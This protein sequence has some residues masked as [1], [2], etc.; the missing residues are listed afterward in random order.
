[1]PDSESFEAFY[2]R[3]VGNVTS[4]MHAL[5][6]DDSAADH[7]IREAY[8]RAYQQWY[9]IGSYPDTEGWV[10]AV[11][12]EAYQR[13]RPMAAAGPAR[14]PARPGHDPARPGHD[15]LSMPG[16]F[17]SAPRSPSASAGETTV[18]P[19]ANRAEEQPNGWFT[20]TSRPGGAA[21]DAS[22]SA[23]ARGIGGLLG[24]RAAAAAAP[25]ATATARMASDQAAVSEQPTPPGGPWRP[26]RPAGFSAGRRRPSATLI[27]LIVVVAVGAA[28]GIGYL[29]AGGHPAKRPT[30]HHTAAARHGKPTV[31]MLA[32][33]KTGSLSAIPW[34]LIGTGWTLAEVSTAPP[35]PDGTATDGGTVTTYLVDPVGGKYQI[36]TSAGPPP[37]L[38]AWSGNGQTALFEVPPG[39]AGTGAGYELLSLTTG[40]MSALSL[41]A[42][43]TVVGF[44]RPDGLNILAVN[45]TATAFQL[46]RFNLEGTY[47]A[48]IGSLPVKPGVTPNWPDCGMDCGAL[49]SPTGLYAIWGVDGDEMQFLSNAGGPVIRRLAV[50]DSGSPSSCVPLTW[51]NADT[52]LA[53][54]YA[55]DSVSREL[56]LVPTDGASPTALTNPSGSMSGGGLETGAW[57]A[58]GAVYVNATDFAQCPSAASGPGGLALDSVSGGSLQPV[59]VTGTTNNHTSVVSALDGR[60][61]VLAETSC[62]GSSALL[63]LNP[64]TGATQTL[65]SA[66]ASEVGVVAAAPFGL[67]P[68]ATGVGLD[69]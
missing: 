14:D 69:G 60:L 34:S 15:P 61:L 30:S 36:Q 33:G 50:P 35:G 10:L 20:P 51:W 40:S 53:S 38:L 41:P 22:G 62:N 59:S 4:Q 24:G 5:S 21:A 56:W 57:Q 43:V 17:R 45:E 16:L 47:Q 8:A 55:P 65:L 2:A 37:V 66:P 1:M 3:T 23:Q 49:S 39:S 13:R 48:T 42:G 68:T 12:R 63:W 67:G 28:A 32:A 29:I 44:T 11:A 52:V 26:G 6:G 64:S 46:E 27:A 9:E 18:A 19:P 7:A 31:Q 54:C 25:S 58:A